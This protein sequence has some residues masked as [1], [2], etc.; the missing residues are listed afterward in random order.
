MVMTLLVKQL[1]QTDLGYQVRTNHPDDA[2][3]DLYVPNE[4][5][6]APGKVTFIHH[7]VACEMVSNK[8]DEFLKR[9][10][11]NNVSYFLVPRSSISKTPLIMANSIGIIDTGYRG[12]I[13]AAVYNM[14]SKDY[15]VS[16][17]TRLFQ[18]VAP[19]LEPFRVKLV[20]E[21]SQ[22]NRNAGGF[23]STGE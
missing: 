10:V 16:S 19:S 9:Y 8:Y 11:D 15:T 5:V 12:E 3:M 22:T 7:Q 20:D 17:G 2:G 21:L 23:G 4:V 14:S 6:C 13:I 18:I 1:G